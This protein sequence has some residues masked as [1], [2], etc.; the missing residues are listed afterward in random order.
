M[1]FSLLNPHPLRNTLLLVAQKIVNILKHS[2]KIPESIDENKRHFEYHPV[3]HVS[4]LRNRSFEPK[5]EKNYMSRP[6]EG[7][8]T[9]RMAEKKASENLL[10]HKRNEIAKVVRTVALHQWLPTL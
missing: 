3:S 8:A 1:G 9:F 7:R 2:L 10:P 6:M 4:E 5:R